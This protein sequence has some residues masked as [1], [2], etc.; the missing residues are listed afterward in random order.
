[1]PCGGWPHNY[2][3]GRSQSI[4]IDGLASDI[5]SLQCGVPMQGSVLGP[6]L[7]TTYTSIGEIARH[8]NLEIHVYGDDHELYAYFKV[9]ISVSQLQAPG[10]LTAC[11]ANVRLWLAF[12]RLQLNDE[13]T[14]FMTICTPHCRRYISTDPLTVGATEV[15]AVPRARNL[16]IVVDQAVSMDHHIQRLCHPAFAQLRNTADGRHYVTRGG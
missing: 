4:I 13:K 1:M 16:G 7:F 11:V 15:A 12:N 5:A 10:A 6:I 3:H 8:H 9:K 14:E 2:L